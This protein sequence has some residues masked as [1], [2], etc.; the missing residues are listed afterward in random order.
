MEA[1]EQISDIG[2]SF[3]FTRVESLYKEKCVETISF[4]DII[5]LVYIWIFL[6]KK[7]HYQLTVIKFVRN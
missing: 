3:A 1:L 4:Y 2:L 5:F 6:F 7:G